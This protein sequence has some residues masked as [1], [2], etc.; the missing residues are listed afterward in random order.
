MPRYAIDRM[1][2]PSG[3][4]HV[5]LYRIV[6]LAGSSVE[7]LSRMSERPRPVP[8][9]DII[10]R[11]SRSKRGLTGLTSLC[12]HLT[13]QHIFLPLVQ[14]SEF[15]GECGEGDS[16]IDLG[17]AVASVSRDRIDRK[18]R[19]EPEVISGSGNVCK[20]P[21]GAGD[22][23]ANDD[24]IR[25]NYNEC[26]SPEATFG[27]SVTVFHPATSVIRSPA[28]AATAVT[29]ANAML[30][31]SLL[32]EE[33]AAFTGAS[34]VAVYG[35]RA[36]LETILGGSGDSDSTAGIGG[37]VASDVR[38]CSEYAE[39]SALVKTEAATVLL[40]SFMAALS[41][42]T[43]ETGAAEAAIRSPATASTAAT[44]KR[45]ELE[46]HFRQWWR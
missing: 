9:R 37:P 7:T 41:P 26:A 42:T 23:A 10:Y 38:D 8:T 14:R 15:L 44:T 16:T 21:V 2:R 35:E 43:N 13:D 11:C 45:A 19:V 5:Y 18:E 1:R 3:H 39:C 29:T 31:T 34:R 32:V 22:T 28:T 6:T 17:D 25:G 40:E 12:R 36:A 30:R 4:L 27:G 24:R 46:G 20:A 33:A